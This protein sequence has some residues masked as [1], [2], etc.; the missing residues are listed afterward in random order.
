MEPRENPQRQ[1]AELRIA[2]RNLVNRSPMGYDRDGRYCV[3][4]S[5]TE[6]HQEEHTPECPWLVAKQLLEK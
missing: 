3:Y 5:Q 6:W 4:C 2:L 1:L